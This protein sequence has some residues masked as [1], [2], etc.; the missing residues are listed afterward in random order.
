MRIDNEET[1]NL[2]RHNVKDCPSHANKDM[3]L[4]RLLI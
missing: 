3:T 1:S 2:K 4:K